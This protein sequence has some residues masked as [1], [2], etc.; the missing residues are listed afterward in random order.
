VPLIIPH[1]ATVQRHSSVPYLWRSGCL[2][3]WSAL[4]SNRSAAEMAATNHI[5]SEEAF[6]DYS[7]LSE[8]PLK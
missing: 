4:S 5:E 7:F 8:E 1:R 6:P 2:C 3:G